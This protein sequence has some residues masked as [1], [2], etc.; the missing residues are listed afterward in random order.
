MFKI[1]LVPPHVVEATSPQSSSVQTRILKNYRR[2]T[3]VQEEENQIEKVA[4][5]FLFFKCNI[6]YVACSILLLKVTGI[7][8]TLVRVNI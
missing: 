7:E 6:T 4:W 5:V 8:T 1:F 3:K 2:K